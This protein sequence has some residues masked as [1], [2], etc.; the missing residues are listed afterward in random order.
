MADPADPQPSET[1]AEVDIEVTPAADPIARREQIRRLQARISR[2]DAEEQRAAVPEPVAPRGRGSH[3]FR[4]RQADPVLQEAAAKREF[5]AWDE[6]LPEPPPTFI[7]RIPKWV[8]WIF[9]LF[10]STQFFFLGSLAQR[11]VLTRPTEPKRTSPTEWDTSLIRELDRALADFREG[12]LA[13]GRQAAAALRTKAPDLPGL[14]LLDA[15]AGRTEARSSM[16]DVTLLREVHSRTA[17]AYRA[18]L[19]RTRNFALQ[20]KLVEALACLREAANLEPARPE[21][22]FYIGEVMRRLGRYSDAI[23]HFERAAHA[24]RPGWQPDRALIDFR[25]RITIAES[26]RD[27]TLAAECAAALALPNPAPEWLAL[28]AAIKLLAGNLAET[29]ASLDRLKLAC[30]PERRAMLLEDHVFRSLLNR[31]ELR[32]LLPKRSS[33][34]E[35][36]VLPSP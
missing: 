31:N 20:L 13:D 12:R 5:R 6:P 32:D 19:E 36:G 26:G 28:D 1:D 21:P 27:N 29:R 15:E 34:L 2:L 17:F 14:A 7:R 9:G 4:M 3:R 10:V 23:E 16:V 33:R 35:A 22:P 11:W 25:R 24:A 30:P 8:L 18:Q